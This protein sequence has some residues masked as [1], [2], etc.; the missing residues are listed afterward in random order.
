[1]LVHL[2]GVS[3][4]VT[5]SGNFIVQAFKA[6]NRVMENGNLSIDPVNAYH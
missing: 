3:L 4:R 6:L 2:A 5:L 1:M